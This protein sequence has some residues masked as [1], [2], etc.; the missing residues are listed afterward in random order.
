MSY[1]QD[2][3][4]W[5]DRSAVS[6]RPSAEAVEAYYEAR[7]AAR[8]NGGLRLAETALDGLQGLHGLAQTKVQTTPSLAFVSQQI[9]STVEMAC[10]E[11]L[12]RYMLR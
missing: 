11:R 2:I 3:E 5:S 6:R 4:R 7:E 10:C 12:A 9:L 8:I 1:Q